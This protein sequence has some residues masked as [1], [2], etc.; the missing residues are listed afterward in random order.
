[1]TPPPSM[2]LGTPQGANCVTLASGFRF[3]FALDLKSEI[4]KEYF[5]KMI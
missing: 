3:S 1:M 5:T 2:M 4:K